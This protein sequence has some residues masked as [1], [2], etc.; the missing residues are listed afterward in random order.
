MCGIFFKGK[1]MRLSLVEIAL[2][3][4]IINYKMSPFL[5]LEEG[6]STK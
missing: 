5:E 1:L 6:I 3:I 2:P 4:V